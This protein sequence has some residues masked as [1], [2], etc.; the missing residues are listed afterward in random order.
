MT[1]TAPPIVQSLWVG[2]R[3]SVME[4]LSIRSFLAHGHPFHLY[5]YSPLS[6]V[7]DGATVL[8][9]AD[10]LP[11]SEIFCYN[12][13]GFGRGSVAAFSNMFR[14]K[15]LLN[16]GGWWTDLDSICMKPLDF[17]AD[18]VAGYDDGSNGVRRIASGM[19]KAPAGSPIMRHCLDA[20]REVD[21]ARL[22]YG[23]TGPKLLN[24]P[25]RLKLAPIEIVGPEVFYPIHHWQV[26][27]LIQ[28]SELPRACHAIHLWN[29]KWRHDW[30]DP[31]ARYEPNCIYEQLKR[32]YG[33]V[34]PR[35]AR[36]GPGW[37]SIARYTLRQRKAKRQ[38][39]KQ[40]A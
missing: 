30:L 15:L 27:R 22:A 31:D 19:L 28:L 5:A 26:W 12:A 20:C 9:G 23:D 2:S 24:E 36:R 7:P 38:Q 8:P 37:W 17:S 18:H 32:M 21:R 4:Q 1:R 13:K 6:G 29:S 16:R 39:M 40:A 33:V 35:G 11:E 34:S 14:Y 10:I 25:I 3:L